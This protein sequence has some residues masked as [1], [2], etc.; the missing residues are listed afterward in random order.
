MWVFVCGYFCQWSSNKSLPGLC[1]VGA[2]LR[3]KVDVKA[4]GATLLNFFLGFVTL[5]DAS[6]IPYSS[7]KVV[8]LV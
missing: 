7:A 1:S 5:P 2:G 8:S 4:V 6:A 3:S